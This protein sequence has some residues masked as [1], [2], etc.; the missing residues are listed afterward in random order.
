MLLS[1]MFFPPFSKNRGPS[2]RNDAVRRMEIPGRLVDLP[3][4]WQT[5]ESNWVQVGEGEMLPKNPAKLRLLKPT[6][7]GLDGPKMIFL[8]DLGDF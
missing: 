3:K 1:I 6:N 7:G 4:V 8:L 5:K 2:L